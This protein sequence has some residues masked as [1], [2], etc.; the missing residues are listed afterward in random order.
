MFTSMTGFQQIRIVYLGR[1]VSVDGQETPLRPVTVTN[2]RNH[3]RVPY[4]FS[5]TQNRR[6]IVSTLSYGEY[7]K[8][9]LNQ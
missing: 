4:N 2:A 3:L 7:I 9:R 6:N 8:T 5:Y 1:G